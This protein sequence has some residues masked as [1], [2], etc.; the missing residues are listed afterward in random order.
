MKGKS[1]TLGGGGGAAEPGLLARQRPSSPLPVQLLERGG[2]LHLGQEDFQKKGILTPLQIRGYCSVY[3]AP[4]MLER[5]TP[6]AG[7]WMQPHSTGPQ[8][9]RGCDT[10][11]SGPR[12]DDNLHFKGQSRTQGAAWG[13]DESQGRRQRERQIYHDEIRLKIISYKILKGHGLILTT[14]C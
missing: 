1:A 6:S 8:Q 4:L 5:L 7:G 3:E 9:N 10:G 2:Q 13:S 14:S 11:S 12:G